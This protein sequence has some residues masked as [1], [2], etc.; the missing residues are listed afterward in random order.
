MKKDIINTLVEESV[1]AMKNAIC[2]YSNYSVGAALL[3]KD[4]KIITGFNIESKAYPT[5]LCAERVAIFSSLAQGYNEFKLLAVTTSD[6]ATP[7]GSCR[8]IIHEFAGNIQIII[9]DENG[10]HHK[11]STSE[12]LPNPFG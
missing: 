2:P 10:N 8:Q 1:K 6:G 3:T 7:C 5:T 11:T 12:L 9:S 4:E